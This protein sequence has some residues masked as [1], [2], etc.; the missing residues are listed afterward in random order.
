MRRTHRFGVSPRERKPGLQSTA[1]L[2]MSQTRL[3][4]LGRGESRHSLSVVNFV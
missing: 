1:S 3:N 4:R 2:V